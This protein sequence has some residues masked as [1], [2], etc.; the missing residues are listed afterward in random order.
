MWQ[1]LRQRQK[2]PPAQLRVGPW[3]ISLLYLQPVARRYFS[4][5]TNI[6]ASSTDF[7]SDT[8]AFAGKVSSFCPRCRRTTGRCFSSSTPRRQ[9][10]EGAT[11]VVRLQYYGSIGRHR[12]R[13]ARPRGNVLSASL[14]R[15]AGSAELDREV[16]ALVHRA[17]PV[18]APPAGA[19]RS[20]TAPVRFSTR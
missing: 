8:I 19:R 6:V 16:I 18:P 7:R 5:P 15:S 10:R 20:I 11:Q 17:S 4:N 1:V 13:S 9:A 2:P 3:R 14:A 12:L